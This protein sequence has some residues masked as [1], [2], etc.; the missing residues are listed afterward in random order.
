[1][2]VSKGRIGFSSG[3][4]VMLCFLAWLVL[5]DNSPFQEYF[6]NHVGL[7]NLIRQL[8]LLPYLVLV[9]VR[10]STPLGDDILILTIESLQWLLVGYFLSRLIF[11]E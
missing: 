10:P 3:F 2:R 6:L 8:L 11:R 1:M 4:S 5:G 9:V 7:P